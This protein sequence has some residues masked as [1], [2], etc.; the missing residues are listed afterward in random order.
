MNTFVRWL[1]AFT[2]QVSALTAMCCVA[3]AVETPTVPQQQITSRICSSNDKVED[4]LP[5]PV[6]EQRNSP[7]SYLAQQGFTQNKDGSWACYISDPYKKGS[8]FTLFKV[9]QIDGKLIASSFLENG[10]LISGQDNRSLDL[11]MILVSNYTKAQEGT[12]LSI[13]KYLESFI[14][15]V[16][17]GKVPTSLRGYLFDQKSRGLVLYHEL[18]Q[19][20]I[21]GTAIT[22]NISMS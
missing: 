7:L 16:K 21:K 5:P 10:S 9:Q 22:I 2:I 14:S 8:Y 4:M 3:I 18:P 13:H 12:R 15:L 1:S 20:Q 11:F 17:Q 6:G 19:G